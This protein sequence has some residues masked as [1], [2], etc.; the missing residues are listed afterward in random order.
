MNKARPWAIIIV[1]SLMILFGVAEVMT[2][3]THNFFG[4]TT[5]SASIFAYSAATI[6][7]FY[8]VAGLLTLTMRKWAAAL[9]TVL[10]G[11]DVIGR[12][13]L[14]MSGLYPTSSL[15]NALAIIGGT[16]IAV[17]FAIYIGWKWKIFT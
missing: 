1:A 4:I 2:G 8:I 16:G 5:S 12:V 3:L 13:A 14:V 10:L 6:G 9:A 15:E 17:I 11:A 7:A